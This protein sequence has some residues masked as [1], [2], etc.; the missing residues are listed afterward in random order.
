MKMPR[1]EQQDLQWG[2]DRKGKPPADQGTSNNQGADNLIIGE[3]WKEV[4]CGQLM[5]KGKDQ[6]GSKGLVVDQD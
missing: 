2:D 4:L 5:T 6:A 3:R 1:I